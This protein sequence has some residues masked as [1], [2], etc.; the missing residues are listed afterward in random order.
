MLVKK[1]PDIFFSTLKLLKI[2]KEI[3]IANILIDKI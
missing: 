2:N 1:F 3:D